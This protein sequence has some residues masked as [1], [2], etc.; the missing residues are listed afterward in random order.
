MLQG[1]YLKHEQLLG[2]VNRKAN[3][4]LHI[5]WTI[6]VNSQRWVECQMLHEGGMTIDRGGIPS[7]ACSK[8]YRSSLVQRNSQTLTEQ[9]VTV[10]DLCIEL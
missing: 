4:S 9:L 5:G 8:F 2:A 7:V 3:T 10:N 6:S 1:S